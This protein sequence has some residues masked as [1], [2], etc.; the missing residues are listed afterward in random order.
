[1]PIYAECDTA[2]KDSEGNKRLRLE[3]IDEKIPNWLR[4]N[5][6]DDDSDVTTTRP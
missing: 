6:N 3:R 5:G 4:K 1:M 2:I